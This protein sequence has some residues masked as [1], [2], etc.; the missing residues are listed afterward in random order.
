MKK[1]GIIVVVESGDLEQKTR[2]LVESIRTFGGDIANSKIWAV[3][4]RKGKPLQKETLRFFVEKEVEFLDI[5]RN[6][7][8]HLYGFANKIYATAYIEKMYG[9]EYDT[10]LFL[11]CDVV[12]INPID[13]N[14]LD[15]HYK[16][17][18]KP[19]EE[20]FL[21]LSKHERLTDFWRMIYFNCE[22]SVKNIWE[23][24]TTV[25][26][27]KVL[28]SFNSGVIFSKGDSGFY[29]KWLSSFEK[30]TND[31]RAYHLPYMEFYLLEQSLFSAVIL[32]NY[33]K[34]DIKFLDNNYNFPFHFSAELRGKYDFNS[35][36]ILHYHH[37]FG[38][39]NEVEI[40]KLPL[41][42]YNWFK[43]K[44]PLTTENPTIIKRYMSVVQYVFWRLRNKNY[45]RI[46]SVSRKF[47]NNE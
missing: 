27:K 38:P 36:K 9:I 31:I 42:L 46:R 14:F 12:V 8:W 43:R 44:L 29:N 41:S 23:V 17:A 7:K 34:E 5:N 30:I 20:K 32:K 45:I 3:K 10:L 11:D 35:V 39:G 19:I 16:I 40:Q 47:F 21:V 18:V 26:N 4:P 15:S 33:E 28:A 22:I 1:L 25:D 24:K 13:A 2:L 6:K 37:L